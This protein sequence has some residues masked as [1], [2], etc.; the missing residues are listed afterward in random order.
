MTASGDPEPPGVMMFLALIVLIIGFSCWV[1]VVNVDGASRNGFVMVG[2]SAIMPSL[3]FFITYFLY[4]IVLRLDK[5][6]EK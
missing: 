5:I 3:L 6:I 1:A 2:I 4:L